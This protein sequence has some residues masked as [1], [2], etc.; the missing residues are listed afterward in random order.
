LLPT[1]LEAIGERD[2]VPQ[3]LD[4]HSLWP[5]IER[6][7]DVAHKY[8][9]AGWQDSYS[10][11]QAIRTARY[12]LIRNSEPGIGLQIDADTLQTPAGDAMRETLRNWPR[13]EIELYDLAQD[14]WERNNLAG[15][16]DT[17]KIESALTRELYDW[18]SRT[19]T[20]ILDVTTLTTLDR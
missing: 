20:P 19:D 6:G 16:P 3:D 7:E 4:G 18:L 17:L 9:F 12:K 13:P 1:L 15:N 14:P 8:I 11:M 10:G 2:R 5:F